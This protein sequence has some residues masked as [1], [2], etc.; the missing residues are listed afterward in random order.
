VL[1]SGKDDL[2]IPNVNA[3]KAQDKIKEAED[4]ISA[5]ANGAAPTRPV[6]TRRDGG[7]RTLKSRS[8]DDD[9]ARRA[10]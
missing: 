10:R 2:H 3:A 7:R 5:L 8:L 1:D 9:A 6:S 4:I